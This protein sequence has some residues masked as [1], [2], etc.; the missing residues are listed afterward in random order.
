MAST[1]LILCGA[2]L[3]VAVRHDDALDDR[4][5]RSPDLTVDVNES[6]AITTNSAAPAP[7]PDVDCA[8]LMATVEGSPELTRFRRDLEIDLFLRDEGFS[9]LERELVM[10]L[11]GFREQ[12]A[13]LAFRRNHPIE[14]SPPLS[15]D[16]RR[17][18]GDILQRAGILRHFGTG[19]HSDIPVPELTFGHHEA[20]R[21]IEHGVSTD[22]LTELID[23]SGI[24]PT[25]VSRYGA[26]SL[27]RTAA[28]HGR[29]DL[30]RFLLERGVDPTRKRGSVLDDLPFAWE[31]NSRKAMYAEVIDLLSAAGDRPY[32]PS[33]VDK[34][35]EAMPDYVR[36]PRL[37]AE[38]A[39]AVQTTRVREA[40]VGLAE[41]VAVWEEKLDTAAS[42]ERRCRDRGSVVDN[43]DSPG[44]SGRNESDLVDPKALQRAKE[45]FALAE[46][47]I[48]AGNVPAETKAL[49][50]MLDLWGAGLWKD[51]FAVADEW[52]I[53][54]E[55]LL[56]QS[57]KHGAPFEVVMEAVRRNGGRIPQDAVL[58]LAY[59][60]WPGATEVAE[61]LVAVYGMDA[62]YIGPDGRNA[63]DEL[64]ER[65]YNLKGPT[66]IGQSDP[67]GWAMAQFLARQGVSVAPSGS[68]PDPLQ[69]VLRNALEFP[70]TLPAVVEYARLLVDQGATVGSTHREFAAWLR[71]LNR[72]GYQELVE[73]VPELAVDA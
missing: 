69:R 16:R 30:V 47:Q 20:A 71:D 64:V 61:A 37:H 40:A 22:V 25:V 46:E 53:G 23:A 10:D 41:L 42:I 65:F 57:L 9:W 28:I 63:Y 14:T 5:E 13:A 34:I 15:N 49:V 33:T 44:G 67:A 58:H 36:V 32:L 27:V 70:F 39:K 73:A 60:P 2:V 11:A 50:R 48:R 72:E 24:D 43:R 7:R 1:A 59:S 66:N 8:V 29:P 19:W 52:G 12:R 21:A 54:Y 68:R 35:T 26:A 45:L 3:F 62:H 6:A 38:S 56:L 17:R 4:H 18:L 55:E 51:A 31:Q